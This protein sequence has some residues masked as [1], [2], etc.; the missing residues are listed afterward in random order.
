MTSILIHWAW[1][2]QIQENILQLGLFLEK[3]TMDIF[4]ETLLRSFYDTTKNCHFWGKAKIMYELTRRNNFVSHSTLHPSV[5]KKLFP[6][7]KPMASFLNYHITISE[8][9]NIVSSFIKHPDQN[10]NMATATICFIITA[11]PCNNT[12]CMQTRK[13]NCHHQTCTSGCTL[14][15]E[16]QCCT[17]LCSDNSS[18]CCFAPVANR[19]RMLHTATS[20]TDTTSCKDTEKQLST[21]QE[22]QHNPYTPDLSITRNDLYPSNMGNILLISVVRTPTQQS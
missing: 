13:L 5:I 22:I 19:N 12:P 10:L 20:A 18:W 7:P 8:M 4:A 2:F 17:W 16:N 21:W 9:Q 14:R 1:D 11:S 6:K 15:C 3:C